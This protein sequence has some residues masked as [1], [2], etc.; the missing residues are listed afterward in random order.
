MQRYD[1]K[2]KRYVLTSLKDNSANTVQTTKKILSPKN[3]WGA[4]YY[5]VS[6]MKSKGKTYY[7]LLGW[8]GNNKLSNKKVIE[9]MSFSKSGRIKFGA[10]IFKVT[11][12]YK[13]RILFEFS[14]DVVMSL[15]FHDKQKL[16]V[17]DHLA[18]LASNLSGERVFY[19]PDLSYD[20]FEL[21]K[22]K[23]HLVSN[24]KINNEERPN[25]PLPKQPKPKKKTE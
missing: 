23:W 18:P 8:D 6:T 21:K 2:N 22:G 20:A 19:G 13:K 16:I 4:Y 24:I 14:S 25:T 15:K 5:D 3:W 11:K 9:P 7:I 17:F 1:K 10:N 12:G